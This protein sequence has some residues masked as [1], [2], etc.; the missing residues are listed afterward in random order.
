LIDTFYISEESVS[1]GNLSKETVFSL[2][3]D[4]R[5]ASPFLERAVEVWYPHLK[6]VD[7]KGYDHVDI[8]TSQKYDLKCFTKGGLR[9]APSV[10]IGA[11][12]K[13]DEEKLHEHASSIS[14]ICCDIINFPK[15]RVKFISGKE[16]IKTYPKGSIPFSHKERFFSCMDFGTIV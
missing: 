8:H 7:A 6:F 5:V 13:I 3:K 10:M 11:G 12:R 4:G 1:F 16:L 14:Y 2:F 9:F 15:I